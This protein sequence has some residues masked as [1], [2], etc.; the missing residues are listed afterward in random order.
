MP[1]MPRVVCDERKQL[2]FDVGEFLGKGGFAACYRLV[3]KV[4]TSY[5]AKVVGKHLI[6]TKSHSEKVI[7]IWSR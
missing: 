6:S 5:A 4:G 1:T 2:Y 7:L 3:D